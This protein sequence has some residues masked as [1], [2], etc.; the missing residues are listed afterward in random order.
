MLAAVVVLTLMGLI[1]GFLL[2]FAAR[3]FH[4]DADPLVE[5]I[6]TM[7]PGTHCGQ[8]GFA[9][10]SPAAE[11]I[12]KGEA[13]ITCCPPGGKQLA[14]QLAEKLGIEANLDDMKEGNFYAVINADLCT[15]CTRCYK[16]CPT[17]AIVGANKQIHMVIANA[18]T[19]CGACIK[20]CPENCVSLEPEAITL[21][22]W[23]WNKPQAA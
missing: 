3:L 22:N 1:L 23:H 10:C 16:V 7:M 12:A 21:D 11:A 9:G 6:T 20:A 15:G 4:V 8:C 19:S 13:E 14:A 2:G 17:D 18:C 5:E